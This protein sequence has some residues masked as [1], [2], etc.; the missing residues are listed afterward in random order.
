VHTCNTLEW[1]ENDKLLLRKYNP[2]CVFM[3]MPDASLIPRPLP[4]PSEG[5]SLGT[6]LSRYKWYSKSS[7]ICVFE[8][9]ALNPL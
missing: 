1:V 3:H 2:V 9:N 4:P 6:R 8:V 7:K 5:R